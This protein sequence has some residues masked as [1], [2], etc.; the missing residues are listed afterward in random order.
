MK[1]KIC[2]LT[3]LEDALAA[4]EYGADA[5]GFIFVPESPRFVSFEDVAE[6]TS[7][8]P[9]FVTTVGV[10]N[11]AGKGMQSVIDRCAIDLIQLYGAFP[12]E[13]SFDFPRRIIQVIRVQDEKSL[14]VVPPGPVRAFLLDTYREEV[15]GG[16]GVSF[17]WDIAAKAKR[18]GKVILAGGLTPENV[19]TAI[20]KVRPYGV[21]VSS[22]VEMRPGKKDHLKLKA[23]IKAAKEMKE[24]HASSE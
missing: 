19:Q 11:S 2:G 14:D 8:L 24:T 6:I 7:K 15:L 13:I 4:V 18:F 9:P 3:N 10:F 17:D 21:D 1:V 20:E 16:S 23:F 12:K 5:V 22:G